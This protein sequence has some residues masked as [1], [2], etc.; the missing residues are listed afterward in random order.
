VDSGTE[1]VYRYDDAA[2]RTSGSQAAAASFALAAGSTNPQGIADPPPA[3]AEAATA[4]A[5][6]PGRGRGPIRSGDGSLSIVIRPALPPGPGD[7]G[8]PPKSAAGFRPSPVGP[9]VV[10]PELRLAP[11][12]A[13]ARVATPW[14]PPDPD[15]R[16]GAWWAVRLDPAG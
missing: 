7:T 16:P 15:D 4:A 10:L 6:R 11:E 2:G 13:S 8:G 12:A 1:R 5:P 14:L 3:A 9:A